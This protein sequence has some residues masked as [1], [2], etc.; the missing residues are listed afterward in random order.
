MS[1][2]QFLE[3]GATRRKN[4]FVGLDALI[5]TGQGD[6]GE[7]NVSPKDTCTR[8]W[9]S[10]HFRQSFSFVIVGDP[11]LTNDIL[12]KKRRYEIGSRSKCIVQCIIHQKFSN[13]AHD[14]LWQL[15][16]VRAGWDSLL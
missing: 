9:K 16:G 11:N 4:D 14:G 3:K 10:F 15:Y 12:D 13:I 6:I 8:F 5:L 1:F 2:Q 7:V